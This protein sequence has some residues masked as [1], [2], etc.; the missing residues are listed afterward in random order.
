MLDGTAFFTVSCGI[1]AKPD[2]TVKSQDCV[3]GKTKIAALILSLELVQ[4]RFA[5]ACDHR[6]TRR[7]TGGLRGMRHFSNDSAAKSTRWRVLESMSITTPFPPFLA[8]SVSSETPLFSPSSVKHRP[9]GINYRFRQR[10]TSAAHTSSTYNTMS[11]R[12]SD[13]DKLQFRLKPFLQLISRTMYCFHY[14]GCP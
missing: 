9:K 13:R 1:L 5:T 8:E 12:S 6:T 7:K 14:R 3:F 4:S 2:S 11:V 10:G